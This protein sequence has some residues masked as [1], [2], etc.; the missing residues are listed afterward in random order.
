[1]RWRCNISCKFLRFEQCIEKAQTGKLPG[2]YSRSFTT[3]LQNP[4]WALGTFYL[5]YNRIRELFCKLIGWSTTY[6]ISLDGMS[7]QRRNVATRLFRISLQSVI[8]SVTY[9][10]HIQ[11]T[12]I[13]CLRQLEVA[14][15]SRGNYLLIQHFL[16]LNKWLQQYLLRRFVAKSSYCFVEVNSV[17]CHFFIWKIFDSN[18]I[19]WRQKTNT[20]SELCIRTQESFL[21]E[22][23]KGRNDETGSKTKNG[24]NGT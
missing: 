11:L 6:C 21:F 24:K 2:S 15:R 5:G 16:R 1:M 9:N 13:T 3:V 18:I 20:E 19:A 17:R 22:R 23:G 8:Y 12:Q 10:R 7:S 4:N 14:E